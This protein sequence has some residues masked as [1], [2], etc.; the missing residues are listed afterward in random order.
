MTDAVAQEHL[1]KQ[2]AEEAAGKAINDLLV[3]LGIDVTNPLSV[4]KDMQ[5]LRTV[6]ERMSDTDFAQDLTYL[7]ELRLTSESIKSKTLVTVVGV[8]VT[9]LL[10]AV[11]L[12]LKGIFFPTQ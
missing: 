1:M 9:G 5:A 7:R 8:V 3:K 4:Q 10:S 11:A 12:G 2:V 6:S